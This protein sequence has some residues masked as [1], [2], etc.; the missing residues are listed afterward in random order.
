M[1]AFEM[2]DLI[3]EQAAGKRPYLEFLKEPSLSCGLYV[4]AAG[5]VDKQQP[6]LE[7]EVYYV[8]HGKGQISVGDEIRDVQPGSVVYVAAHVEHRFHD[9]RE[10]LKILV[11]FAPPESG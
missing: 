9:I 6:H 2:D 8:I 7:D 3:T 11:F 5:S 10:E 1:Q 4:L